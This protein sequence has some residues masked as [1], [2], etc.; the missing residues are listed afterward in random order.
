MQAGKLRHRVTI[1]RPTETIV[2]GEPVVTW[3]TIATRFAEIKSSE[4]R[5]LWNARQVQ[6]D[7][8]HRLELRYDSAIAITSKWRLLLGGRV[9]EILNIN[10]PEERPIVWVI[11]CKEAV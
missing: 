3:S 1:Q 4:G 5:E 6:P 2:R 8:T 10:R 9:L 11:D 7:I